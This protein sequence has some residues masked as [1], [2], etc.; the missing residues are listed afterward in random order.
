MRSPSSHPRRCTPPTPPPWLEPSSSPPPPLPPSLPLPCPPSIFILF[1]LLR[2]VPR[3]QIVGDGVV[4]WELELLEILSLPHQCHHPGDLPSLSESD[5]HERSLG[6]QWEIVART[7]IAHSGVHLLFLLGQ[8]PRR[9]QRNRRGRWFTRLGACVSIVT[10]VI[11][12]V[13]IW[14]TPAPKLRGGGC[15]RLLAP[16]RP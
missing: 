11:P 12:A 10:I 13:S 5:G 9:R 15:A 2:I 3:L 16:T 1:L 7:D 14:A 4:R 6:N 8:K